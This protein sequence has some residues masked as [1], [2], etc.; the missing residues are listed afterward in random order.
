MKIKKRNLIILIAL[1]IVIILTSIVYG[2]FTSYYIASGTVEV[3]VGFPTA[4]VKENIDQNNKNITISNVGNIDCYVRVKIFT[5]PSVNDS[6]KLGNDWQEANDGYIYY[7]KILSPGKESS[8][9]SLEY[10]K[11]ESSNNLNLVPV[12][13]YCMVYYDDSGNPSA[14]WE[15]MITW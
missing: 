10:N 9:I 13:E 12:V 15:Y 3:N 8:Q 5:S 11:N 6:I 2:Y 14:D 4:I 1:F 7:N